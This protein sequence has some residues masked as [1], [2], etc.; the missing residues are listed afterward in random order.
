MMPI[1]SFMEIQIVEKGDHLETAFFG[2]IHIVEKEIEAILYD[3]AN[4]IS[5]TRSD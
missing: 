4:R 5:W 2:E 3:G 1:M